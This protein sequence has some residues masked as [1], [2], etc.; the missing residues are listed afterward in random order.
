VGWKLYHG[1][2]LAAV[3]LLFQDRLGK[4]L[5]PP[6]YSYADLLPWG[7]HPLLDPLWSTEQ[8]TIEH[9]GCEA[10]RVEKAAYI[11]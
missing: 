4:I 11:Q 7:S 5:I 1:A 9:E 2:A 3:A 8:T 6:T 10:T